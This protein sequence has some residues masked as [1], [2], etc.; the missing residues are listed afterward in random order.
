MVDPAPDPARRIDE[1]VEERFQ[2]VRPQG[3]TGAIVAPHGEREERE[4][5]YG[6]D[7]TAPWPDLEAGGIA[8]RAPFY[9]G[10]ERASGRTVDPE[11]VAYWEV[12]AHLRWAVIALQ[13]GDRTL[14]GGEEAL[15]P[16][17]TGRLYPPELELD[18]LT[19]TP[20]ERWSAA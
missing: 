17:L 13:Q 14:S 20:P 4:F 8:P 9:Q 1:A 3:E 18:V 15:D 10:Y 16:A 11:R 7:A 6:G 19:M 12:M 5:T 2:A